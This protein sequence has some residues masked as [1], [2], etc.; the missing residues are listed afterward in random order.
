MFNR[1]TYKGMRRRGSILILAV[2]FILLLITM[3]GFLIDISRIQLAKT[4]LYAV[5]DAVALA[6]A[7]NFET[8]TFSW[9]EGVHIIQG[10]DDKYGC[11]F[12]V[13]QTDIWI[14][15][16]VFPDSSGEIPPL[17]SSQ[18]H[19]TSCV[20]IYDIIDV[21]KRLNTDPSVLQ[22]YQFASFSGKD[23]PYMFD[24]STLNIEVD[25]SR[26][27]LHVDGNAGTIVVA[28]RGTADVHL[29]FGQILGFSKATISVTVQSSLQFY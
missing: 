18:P 14:W 26:S 2:F 3:A 19:Q 10:H 6:A 25:R 4:Q 17:M 5:T 21:Y 20:T 16:S 23:N 11:W 9:G 24:V 7:T 22:Q 13:P 15:N 1:W 28:L 27:Q 8:A 29:I 12:K